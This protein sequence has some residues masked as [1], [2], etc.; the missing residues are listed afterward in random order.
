MEDNDHIHIDSPKFLFL[1]N[2]QYVY[3]CFS[4]S[5][6]IKFWKVGSR[7]IYAIKD[8][9]GKKRLRESEDEEVSHKY[10]HVDQLFEIADKLDTMDAKLSKILEINP[11]LPIPLGVSTLLLDNLRCNICQKSPITP[12][13]IF[14]RC[15]KRILGCQNCVDQWYSGDQGLLKKCPL[16]RGDRGFADT[17]KILGLDDLLNA[18]SKIMRVPPPP[19][20]LPVN[21]D[22]ES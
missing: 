3:F 19:A 8:E 5:A 6:G 4:L 22:E 9:K 11:N 15:C 17:S 16:C 12:P 20:Y 14:V 13:P 1:A 21:L 18:V 10:P 7:K 2:V